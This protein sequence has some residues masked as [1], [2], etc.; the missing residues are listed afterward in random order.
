LVGFAAR[1]EPLLA[2]LHEPLGVLLTTLVWGLRPLASPAFNLFMHFSPAGD[3]A[4]FAR[5]EMKA[6][7]IDDLLHGSRWGLR[8]PVYDL[9]LFS[10]PWGFRLKDIQ[11]PIRFWHGDADHLV[12]LAHGKHQSG[13]VKDAALYVRH[14]ESHL[15]SLAAAEEI[16]NAILSLWPEGASGERRS[17]DSQ[18][19]PR[20]APVRAVKARTTTAGPAALPRKRR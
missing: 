9:M 14:G 18:T 16:L 6:M 8:A 4:V 19:T 1:F 10:R 7:F 17:R 20:R 11:V 5:P 3:Q 12:P 2:R 13:L 15:G